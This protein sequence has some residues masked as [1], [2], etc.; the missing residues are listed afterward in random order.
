MKKLRISKGLGY[1]NM[2]RWNWEKLKDL[3]T[4]NFDL[5]IEEER[6]T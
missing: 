3:N 1:L 4:C 2:L 5:E 6:R